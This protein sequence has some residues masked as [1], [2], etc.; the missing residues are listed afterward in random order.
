MVAVGASF[1]HADIVSSPPL[2]LRWNGDGA[3]A[4]SLVLACTAGE[5]LRGRLRRAHAS[6]GH[7]F[8]A[9][10][11]KAVDFWLTRLVPRLVGQ[12]LL[13]DRLSHAR[14]SADAQ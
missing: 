9:N 10:Q 4:G 12:T 3:A 1:R 2:C 6:P 5:P 8:G 11:E 7:S 14:G 13:D